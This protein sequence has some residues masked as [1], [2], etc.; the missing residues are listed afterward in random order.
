MAHRELRKSRVLVAAAGLFFALLCLW[1]RIAWLQIA[2]HDQFDARA[3]ANQSQ[4]EKILPRRGPIL[5]RRGTPMAHDL[6]IAQV[7]LYR[8]QVTDIKKTAD[9]IARELGMDARKLRKKI[10]AAKGFLWIDREVAPE[11]GERIA[12]LRL[13]GVRVDDETKRFYRLQD[14]ASEILGRTNSDNVGVDGIEYQFERELGGQTGWKT[15]VPTGSSRFKLELPGAERRA[16]KDGSTLVLTIDAELQSIVEHHLARA[17]DSLKAV[18]GFAIFL[19]PWTGEILA[20]ACVPH[21][22]AG[23][24]KNWNFTDMYEPGS[25][26]K[27]VVA[28]ATLEE[29]L[30]KPTDYFTASVTGRAEILP[31]VFL[32]DS[33]AHEGYTFFGAIQNSSNIVCG[34]LGIRLGAERLYRYCTALGFGSLSGVEFPGETSGK[35]RPV[36]AWQPRSTPTIA[37]GQEIAVTPIQLALAY[38]AIANGG[39]LMEPM[40]LKELRAPDGKVLRTWTPQTS[41]RVFSEA[42][43]ATL[44]EMLCAVV[45]SGTATTARTGAIR[46][47]GKTGTAQKYDPRTKGYGTGMYMGSFAGFAPADKPRMVGVVVIDEPHGSQYYGGL[48][49]APVFRE[50]MLDLLRLPNGPLNSSNTVV[51]M[52]PPAVPAVTA[53]DLRLLPASEARHRLGQYGLNVRFEGQGPRVLSQSPA[54]GQPVERGMSVV[55]YLSA[56]SD[57]TGRTLPDLV[58][59]PMRQ[60]IRQLSERAVEMRIEGKGIVV[61]QEPPAGTPLPM[62]GRCR[63]WC[64]DAGSPVASRVSASLA[65]ASSRN[66]RP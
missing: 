32:R 36:S 13:P 6:D 40:L 11:V 57:S 49:A 65:S 61:R 30:A 22:P 58:G 25:T 12:K 55:A 19:D 50:V 39:V 53:P 42:T 10:E 44:R 18:R 17:V 62:S 3:K 63:V 31:K 28:G 64:A 8:P 60:A 14:A 41:H 48:V 56:P 7:A 20:S 15:M 29:K 45:D 21:L 26:F 37:M 38:A 46:I 4:H 9:A 51:A 2:L 54:A 43:T 59:L 34:K 5:D 33:H 1:V 35:L 47:A 27:V 66:N 16:A 23:Q 24:A 52:R